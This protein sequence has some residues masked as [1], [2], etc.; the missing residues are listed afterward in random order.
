VKSV[1]FSEAAARE[2]RR[3]LEI[4]RELAGSDRP[5][6]VRLAV[7]AGGCN[8]SYYD[9]GAAEAI[10]PEDRLFDSR[11]ITIAVDP[12]SRECLADADL[13]IEYT[14]DLVGGA[15]RFEARGG[16]ERQYCDCGLSFRQ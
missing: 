8:G 10:A 6:Q 13:G 9:L 12:A 4:E 7:H 16:S 2:V 3:L 1:E 14:E 11:G 15:F 5:P